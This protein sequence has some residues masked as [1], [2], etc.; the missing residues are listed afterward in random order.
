VSRWGTNNTIRQFRIGTQSSKWTI[1]QN[2]GTTTFTWTGNDTITVGTL[3]EAAFLFDGSVGTDIGK[4]RVRYRAFDAVTQTWGA[5][6]TDAGASATASWPATIRVLPS[7]EV[8]CLG[9]S[10]SS[11]SGANA[12]IGL[13]DD[14]QIHPSTLLTDANLVAAFAGNT[15]S[16]DWHAPSFWCDFATVA[17]RGSTGSANNGT[18]TGDL[19]FCTDDTTVARTLLCGTST[20]AP[21]YANNTLTF[22]GVDDYMRG[23]GGTILGITQDCALIVIGASPQSGDRFVEVSVGGASA[24]II[25]HRNTTSLRAMSSTATADTPNGTGT[26]AWTG[27]RT[28][29][30]T[31]TL[32]VKNGN[33]AEVTSAT[34][35]ANFVPTTITVGADRSATPTGFGDCTVKAILVVRPDYAG[36]HA[37]ANTWASVF[38]GATL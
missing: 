28:G 21:S 33:T 16:A 30:G 20:A 37:T 31:V 4:W 14:V 10:R 25:L 23:V 36:K 32:G 13:I 3:Y 5:W 34:A 17:N 38:H 18:V 15:G 19:N 22:D 27:R 26:R 9:R 8:L 24:A 1:V 6:A 29:S 7:S 11:T 35:I 12:M 2:D